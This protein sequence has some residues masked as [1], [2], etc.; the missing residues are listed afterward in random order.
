MS[1]GRPLR[2]TLSGTNWTATVL[3]SPLSGAGNISVDG[4]TIEFYNSDRCPGDP[5]GTYTW[6]I[7]DETLTFTLVGEDPCGRKGLFLDGFA[8]TLYSDIP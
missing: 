5:G 1:T 4:D 3:G 8:Y 6:A 7:E 2:L